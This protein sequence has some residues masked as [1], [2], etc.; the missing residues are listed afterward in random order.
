MRIVIIGGGFMGQLL[1]TLVPR[2][3]IFDWMPA[4]PKQ[5]D[6]KFGAQ[7]L[8]ES[9][10]EIACRNFN[11]ITAI[12]DADATDE[13][14]L[15]YKKKV[16]KEQDNSDWR[17][18][19]K[20]IMDGYEVLDMPPS[21][22]EYGR[23]ITGVNREK[24]L[25]YFANRE[26]EKY[27]IIISTVPLPFMASLMNV[28]MATPMS[29]PIFVRSSTYQLTQH[30]DWYVNYNADP[31]NPIYRTTFRD[32]MMHEEALESGEGDWRR[33]TPGKIYRSADTPA[34]LDQLADQQVY[35]FGRYA[36]W[37]PE[38]LAH[39]TMRLARAYILRG[40]WT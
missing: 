4:A 40:N 3:R 9:L 36:R 17:S 1:G 38:E 27:D 20:P 32:G 14:I 7:Y 15:A 39:E 24:R 29:R 16:G 33:L 25:L 31:N 26:P 35:C 21:R 19:F 22:V 30:S 6:R 12:D 23:R 18:Q 2:A 8:W 13:K 37:N 11:V 28:K 34:V 5:M 10:P